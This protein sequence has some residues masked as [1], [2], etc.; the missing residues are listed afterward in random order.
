VQ[1]AERAPQQPRLLRLG[2]LGLERALVMLQRQRALVDA[3]PLIGLDGRM[4]EWMMGVKNRAW[5]LDFPHT[6]K[7]SSVNMVNESLIFDPQK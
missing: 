6:K 1:L 5:R 3:R 2:L 4:S 7:L